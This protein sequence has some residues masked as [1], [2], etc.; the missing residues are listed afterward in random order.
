[1]EKIKTPYLNLIKNEKE[2]IRIKYEYFTPELYQ[3]LYITNNIMNI[4]DMGVNYAGVN[5]NFSELYVSPSYNQKFTYTLLSQELINVYNNKLTNI[6]NH[7][8][9]EGSTLILLGENLNYFDYNIYTDQRAYILKIKF[10]NTNSLIN[11]TNS[12]S[13][14][15]KIYIFIQAP[16][17]SPS[18]FGI[19]S[20]SPVLNI[21][22]SIIKQKKISEE[23]TYLN[24]YPT[25]WALFIKNT[26]TQQIT[27]DITEEPLENNTYTNSWGAVVGV[28]YSISSPTEFIT[29]DIRYTGRLI[30]NTIPNSFNNT[31]QNFNNDK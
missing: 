17:A 14:E 21:N 9:I 31:T 28:K 15:R 11:P 13:Y 25:I 29:N 22:T 6:T 8:K 12:S 2:F 19:Y 23:E 27:I 4:Y 18:Y 10:S 16:Y 1:M 3:T 20:P 26:Q 7:W 24:R 5:L 30:I